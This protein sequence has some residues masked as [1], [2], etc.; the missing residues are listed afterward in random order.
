MNQQSLRSPA[1][2]EVRKTSQVDYTLD[3]LHASLDMLDKATLILRDRLAAVSREEVPQKS[4]SGECSEEMLVP[5]AAR[6]RTATQS[7]HCIQQ[8]VESMVERLET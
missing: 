6:I 1:A 2:N 5:V 8:R 7:I 4:P 3:Q